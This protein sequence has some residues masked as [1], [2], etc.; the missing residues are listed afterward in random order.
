MKHLG[1]IGIMRA[2]I[3]GAI[4][5]NAGKYGT[6]GAYKAYDKLFGEDYSVNTSLSDAKLAKERALANNVNINNNI[7]INESVNPEATKQVIMDVANEVI[8]DV[9]NK[10]N[11]NISK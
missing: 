4:A 9:A 5:Y 3:Y 10:V 2:S 8:M 6:L 1:K 11:N 7:T